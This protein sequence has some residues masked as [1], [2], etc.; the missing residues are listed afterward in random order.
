M[1]YDFITQSEYEMIDVFRMLTFVQYRDLK[2]SL[3]YKFILEMSSDIKPTFSYKELDEIMKKY[4][5]LMK[6]Y[7]INPDFNDFIYI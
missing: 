1:I 2:I 7:K 4:K 5:E 3:L 6:K